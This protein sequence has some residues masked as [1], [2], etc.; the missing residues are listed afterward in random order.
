[1]RCP[2]GYGRGQSTTVKASNSEKSKT[3]CNNSYISRTGP[4]EEENTFGTSGK[5]H[6][7]P[8]SSYQPK[9][10][11]VFN[12]TGQTSSMSSSHLHREKKI[13]YRSMFGNVL[14]LGLMETYVQ[15]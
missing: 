2:T 14:L 11:G 12:M 13:S 5:R 1:M 3:V 7:Y 8:E 6:M 4:A 9:I 15:Q 10:Q